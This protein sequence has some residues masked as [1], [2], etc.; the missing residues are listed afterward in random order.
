MKKDE[1]SCSKDNTNVVIKTTK[2]RLIELDSVN[3]NKYNSM[4][5]VNEIELMKLFK[6]VHYEI[7]QSQF[8]PDR[9]D[10]EQMTK[11]MSYKIPSKILME[12]I[13]RVLIRFQYKKQKLPTYPLALVLS[14]LDEKEG[15]SMD[16]VKDLAKKLK[17]MK[18]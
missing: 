2:S 8:R 10:W 6:E 14:M 4:S 9:K 13:R 15:T 3:N 18:R 12:T 16:I 7:Y 17:R 1:R 11:I 5:N